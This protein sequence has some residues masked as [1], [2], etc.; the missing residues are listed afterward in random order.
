MTGLVA[1]TIP[2]QKRLHF[3]WAQW[4]TPKRLGFVAKIAHLLHCSPK[5]PVLKSPGK[6]TNVSSSDR[7]PLKPTGENT[8]ILKQME[9]KQARFDRR[10]CFVGCREQNLVC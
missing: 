5:F 7:L 8:D 2:R 1:A 3:L 4:T 10:R 9:A 6:N